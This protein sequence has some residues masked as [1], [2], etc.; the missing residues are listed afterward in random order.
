VSQNFNPGDI[1]YI[2]RAYGHFIRNT[3]NTD[4]VY[5][6]RGVLESYDSNEAA[7]QTDEAC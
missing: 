5:L 2:K 6:A 1:G 4:L 3:G 7:P